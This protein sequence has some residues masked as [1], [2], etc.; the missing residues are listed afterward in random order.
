VGAFYYLFSNIP[1][2]FNCF[3]R[4]LTGSLNIG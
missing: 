2:I 1:F 4:L 3:L